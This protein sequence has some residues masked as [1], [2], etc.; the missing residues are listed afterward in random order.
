MNLLT[1]IVY[2]MDRSIPISPI[3]RE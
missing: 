1:T 2:Y 3:T